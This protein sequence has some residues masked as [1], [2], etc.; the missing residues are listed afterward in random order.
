MA[1]VVF[2][3]LK[4]LWSRKRRFALTRKVV[5]FPHMKWCIPKNFI[6]SSTFLSS[7]FFSA[8][9]SL[10]LPLRRLIRAMGWTLLLG[11]FLTLMPQDASATVVFFFS[12][13]HWLNNSTALKGDCRFRRDWR[14]KG[15]FDLNAPK[16]TIFF[17]CISKFPKLSHFS[18][19]PDLH[20]TIFLGQMKSTIHTFSAE[21]QTD[22]KCLWLAQMP[23][24]NTPTEMTAFLLAWTHK[25]DF[26][27]AMAFPILVYLV[28]GFNCF[29]GINTNKHRSGCQVFFSNAKLVKFGRIFEPG[30]YFFWTH[31]PF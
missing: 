30:F 29:P 17:A 3:G 10:C 6:G 19:K 18:M 8:E 14:W 5:I 24:G 4:S 21:V 22:W 1:C 25:C 7:L 9:W 28:P 20:S 2:L 11:L 27:S 13:M 23:L 31:K 16:S 12:Q 26:L 15:G